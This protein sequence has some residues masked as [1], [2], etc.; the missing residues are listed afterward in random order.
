MKIEATDQ[1]VAPGIRVLDGNE[2]DATAG[3]LAAIHNFMFVG[4]PIVNPLSPIA[5]NPQPLPPR[6]VHVLP[7]NPC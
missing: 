2:I 7:P 4:S 1:N 6:I 3:G 5:I